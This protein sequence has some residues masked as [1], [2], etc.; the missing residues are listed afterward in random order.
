M[1]FAIHNSQEHHRLGVGYF[2]GRL[3]PEVR[4]GFLLRPSPPQQRVWVLLFR[5]FPLDPIVRGWVITAEQKPIFLFKWARQFR[6][7]ALPRFDEEGDPDFI[8][9]G[10]TAQPLV[11]VREAEHVSGIRL[12]TMYLLKGEAGHSG[13][14]RYRIQMR[15]HNGNTSSAGKRF[16]PH[17]RL[18]ILK[19][20]GARTKQPLATRA[21]L[22][23]IAQ[24]RPSDIQPMAVRFVP[25]GFRGPIDLGEH[26]ARRRTGL[27]R[28]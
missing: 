15:R 2:A 12:S 8:A 11:D 24:V 13:P 10:M 28:A 23:G 9:F 26:G 4:K 17:V 14:A 5:F 20:L 18:G 21:D 1:M 22:F 7:L 27:W 6:Y 16:S 25:L 19:I 3:D